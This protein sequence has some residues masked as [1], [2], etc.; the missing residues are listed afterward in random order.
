MHIPILNDVVLILSLAV[1]VLFLCHRLKVP[2]LVGYLLTGVLVGPYGLKLVS[3]VHDV[4]LL[5]EIGVVLLLFT[6]GLEFSLERLLAIRKQVL[7]GG[8]LQVLATMALAALLGLLFDLTIQQA[9]FAGM[10]TS[11]SSTAIVLKQ[12]QQRAEVDTPHGRMS[13]GILIFQDIAIV[14]MLLITPFLA[15]QGGDGSQDL[16]LSLA[17]GVLIL[18]LVAAAAKWLIPRLL[19]QLV[20]TR[21]HELFLLGIVVLCFGI[22][23]VISQAGLSLAMGAFLAG[24]IISGSEYSH[25]A[26]GKIMPFRD[27]FT[28]FFFVSIGMMLDTRTILEAPALILG[29]T[30]LVL[31]AKGTI[32]GLTGLFLRHPVRT[33]AMGGLALAQIGEFSFILSR[34][35]VEQGLLDPYPYQ[36][37][38]AVAVLTMAA[39]PFLFPL[40][41]QAGE[42][43]ARR[44]PLSASRHEPPEEVKLKD[45]LVIVGYGVNGRN[46]ARA[47]KAVGIPYLIVEMNPDTVSRERA[48]GEPIIYGDAS[49]EPV[50]HQAGIE[51]ARIVVIVINDP[52]ATRRMTSIIRAASPA[53]HLIVRT[54]YLQ[55]VEPLLKLGANDVIPEEFETSVEIFSRVLSRYLVDQETIARIVAE[56]RA[57]GYQMFRSLSLPGLSLADMPQILKDIRI[58]TLKVEPDSP[59]A[60]KQIGRLALR[61]RYGITVVA[62]QRGEEIRANP[63]ADAAIEPGDILFFLGQPEK[64]I[65][66]SRAIASGTLDQLVASY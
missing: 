66:A 12:L 37:F 59:L 49:Q 5:A 21:D 19:D 15:G 56:V 27:V 1:A 53:V 63:G 18:L 45:H 11:L 64:I 51:A 33:A 57:D 22:A 26:M 47:A 54:R 50:L 24:L 20:R 16:S 32:A 7:L 58:S 60:G 65:Q 61:S 44:F 55:E 42:L 39:T 10:L 9:L 29:L 6:I 17:K 28:A 13:L 2:V 35:G 14:P 43:L 3:A 40:A 4:E 41:Q 52:A 31:L 36:L 23:W 46:I 25:Q 34:A 8:P 62:I 48:R 30:L 38:L